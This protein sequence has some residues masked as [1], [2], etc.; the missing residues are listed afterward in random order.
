ASYQEQRLSVGSFSP[1]SS[2]VLVRS[3]HDSITVALCTKACRAGSTVAVHRTDRIATRI[4]CQTWNLTP[5]RYERGA[6]GPTIFGIGVI[7]SFIAVSRPIR[8][9]GK[10]SMLYAFF[11]AQYLIPFSLG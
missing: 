1:K 4:R 6:L 7:C 11:S 5:L 2:L 9:P 10:P 8:I 3:A